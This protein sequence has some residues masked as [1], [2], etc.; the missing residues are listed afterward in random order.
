[1]LPPPWAHELNPDE[2]ITI[3]VILGYVSAME[4][5]R[6]IAGLASTISKNQ[7]IFEMFWKLK[8]KA[9]HFSYGR[10]P[11][12]FFLRVNQEFL[13]LPLDALIPAVPAIWARRG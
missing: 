13:L 12:P 11:L 10:P 7:Y 2:E 6:T 8:N 4:G 5:W 9:S 1:M 3:T